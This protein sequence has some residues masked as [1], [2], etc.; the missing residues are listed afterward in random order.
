M[1]VRSVERPFVLGSTR[2]SVS[3]RSVFA[4]TTRRSAACPS[5]TNVFR[6]LRRKPFA[7]RVAAS[8]I[9][10]GPCFGP[11]STATAATI[12]PRAIRG[13]CSSCCA[14]EPA[15]R[16][17]VAARTAGP[18]KGEGGRGRGQQGGREEGGGC[19]RPPQLLHDDARLDVTQADAA[20]RLRH[21]HA[22]PAHLGELSPELT[23]VAER[24][25]GIAQ[26]AGMRHGSVLG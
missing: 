25:L 7:C 1:L 9:F 4:A 26:G 6:P 23:R 21:E 8:A 2:K 5:T 11:S 14:L 16:S 17:A 20:E 10:S 12:S 24:V 22:R 18:E 19:Q 3:P 15:W 13:R